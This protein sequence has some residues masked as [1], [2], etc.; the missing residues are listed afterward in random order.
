MLKN[1]IIIFLIGAVIWSIYYISEEPTTLKLK[2]LKESYEKDY[3][4]SVNHSKLA[5][6][7]KDFKEPGEVTEACISCHTERHKEIM[8]TAHW[9][10]Q[11]EEYIEGRGIVNIGKKNIINNFCI[12]IAGNEQ[13]CNKCHAGYGWVDTTFDF[14]DPKNVD[15]LVCHDN[16]GDYKK[17]SATGGMPATD[18]N[19]TAAAQ[20]VGKPKKKNC[21]MCHF[22][23][24]GGNNV[25][26]GDLELALLNTNRKV[27]VHMGKDGADLECVQCHLTDKHQMKGRMYSVSS[28][29]V[30]RL[31]CESC[32]TS[33]PHSI[34]VLNEHGVKVACQTC[35]IPVYAKVNPTKMFWDWE[36]ACKTMD[37]NYKEVDSSGATVYLAKKGRFVWQKN[38]TPEYVWFNGTADHY[39]FGDKF[40]TCSVAV[41]INDLKGNYRDRNSKIVPVKIHRTRQPCD[42]VNKTL[43]QPKLWD[44]EYG[45]GALWVDCKDIPIGKMWS[46]AAE[47]GMEYIGLPYSGEYSFINTRM[48]WPVNHMVSPA[49]EA[50]TCK[51]CHTREGGRLDKLRGFYMPGRDYHVAVSSLGTGLILV[52]LI[53]VL[54][55]AIIRIVLSIKRKKS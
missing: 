22:L 13:L 19:L 15:C 29:D 4:P 35:H 40:D 34:D 45:E 20:S 27:D 11:R 18:V 26:H 3:E 10:W 51:E 48:Y 14:E 33:S 54:I 17:G 47:K 21:G 42:P 16:S 43:L 52:S 23:G 28:M 12:G 41:D 31:E 30:D 8:S 2:K 36:K 32:H 46:I 9:K 39:L 5:A 38:V 25:K 55:H 53:G 37:P 24:G 50:L 6:L 7:Q 44:K 49:K 1:V